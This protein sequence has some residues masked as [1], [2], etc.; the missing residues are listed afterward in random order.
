[1]LFLDWPFF[2]HFF[3]LK[4]IKGITLNTTQRYVHNIWEWNNNKKKYQESKCLARPIRGE[5]EKEGKKQFVCCVGVFGNHF[6]ASFSSLFFYFLTLY[7]VDAVATDVLF[8][9][10]LFSGR[11]VGL[12]FICISINNIH[13][14][15]TCDAC[16]TCSESYKCIVALD[17]VSPHKYLMLISYVENAEKDQVYIFLYSNKLTHKFC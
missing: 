3:F 14:T 6:S 10:I 16:C 12:I 17:Y 4:N 8:S 9:F 13:T 1:M 2:S 5:E 15:K 11:S 7:A